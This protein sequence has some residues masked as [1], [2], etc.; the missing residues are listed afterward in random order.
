MVVPLSA[1][2]PA[3]FV[4]TVQT[5]VQSPF[6]ALAKTD[7]ERA[8]MLQDVQSRLGQALST[9][10]S[11][12]TNSKEQAKAAAREKITRIKDQIKTL[13]MLAAGSDPKA[14]AQQAARLAKELA[15]A[16]KEYASAGGTDVTGGSTIM[17]T[18]S[19]N[20]TGTLS[21]AETGT[22]TS[23]GNDASLLSDVDLAYTES[24]GE[25]TE[26]AN[27][28]AGHVLV[29]EQDPVGKSFET[30]KKDQ[31]RQDFTLPESN[32]QDREFATDVKK[33][34]DELKTLLRMQRARIPKG[35]ADAEDD[36]KEGE[37]ALEEAAKSVQ[38]IM[39]QAAAP[40]LNIQA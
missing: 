24:G 2:F 21:E 11:V 8:Q 1:Q 40:V 7:P 5:R 30:D 20:L 27:T 29:E 12:K 13:R 25:D 38:S 6:S 9:A 34:I 14:I 33:M 39:A 22:D 31:D 15:A 36:F 16:V 3:S 19:H 23:T 28:D 35:D 26:T 37:K 4:K 17:P 18:S 32:Q 10:R